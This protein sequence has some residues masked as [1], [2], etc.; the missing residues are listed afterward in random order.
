MSTQSSYDV[1]VY[2]G[3]EAPEMP[4]GTVLDITPADE[5]PAAA[6]EAVRNTDITSADLRSRVLFVT[7][8][9]PEYRFKS[10]LAYIALLGLSRRKVDISFGTD[11]EPLVM[12][13][14]DALARGIV[15]AG[16]PEIPLEVAL[17]NNPEADLPA[18]AKISEV[19][20]TSNP[21]PEMVSHVRYA[22][23]LV[24]GDTNSVTQ[25]LQEFVLLAALRV[26]G[27]R[28]RLPFLASKGAVID[29]EEVRRTCQELRKELRGDD[30]STVLTSVSVPEQYAN[31][32][33]AAQAP[34]VPV[35]EKLGAV[36]K[37]VESPVLD[38]VGEPTGEVTS[39]TLWHCL[40]PQVHTNGDATPSARV[41]VTD[42]GIEGFRCYRCLPER[43]D[44]LRLV[45]WAKDLTGDEAADWILSK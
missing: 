13:N 9:D 20:L 28:E 30:R 14:I 25:M 27:G 45:M 29:T 26:R 37:I 33:Q 3:P 18:S 39:T 21:D 7:T 4:K 44:S 16:K 19:T 43:V 17:L 5:T 8:T 31:L 10:I 42:E 38:E 12:A 40:F 32:V 36:S 11:S 15:D 22:K 23:R 6:I 34:M 1:Y 24:I 41:V 35:L 2:V